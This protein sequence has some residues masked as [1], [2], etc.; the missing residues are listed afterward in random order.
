V[1]LVENLIGSEVWRRGDRVGRATRLNY[2]GGQRS[3]TQGLERGGEEMGWGMAMVE[4]GE[5]RCPFYRVGGWEGTLCDEGND[6]QRS[7]PLM[8]FKPLVLGGER[9]GRHPV[10]KWK[11]RRLSST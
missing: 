11:R 9:R 3:S 8:T 6:Q 10:Q 5:V 2:G 1:G 7:A 4:Y